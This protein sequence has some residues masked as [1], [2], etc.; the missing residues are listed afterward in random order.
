VVLNGVFTSPPTIDSP[1]S[2]MRGIV[3]TR[4]DSWGWTPSSQRGAP[5]KVSHIIRVM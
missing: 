2:A 5:K 1:A 4:G 3:I